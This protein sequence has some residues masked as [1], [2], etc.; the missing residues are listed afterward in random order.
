[1]L[2]LTHSK[3][4]NAM[5]TVYTTLDYG[6][7]HRNKCTGMALVPRKCGVYKLD[8]ESYKICTITL[9]YIQM[10]ILTHTEVTNAMPTVYTT[11]DYDYRHKNKC[12]LIILVPGKCAV[13][14]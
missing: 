13:Y 6:Y 7:R 1:M 11:L 5:P 4:I 12:T 8:Q 10:L 3:V 14:K 9:K 2:I